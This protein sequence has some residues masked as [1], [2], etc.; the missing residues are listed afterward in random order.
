[1]YKAVLEIVSSGKYVDVTDY[2]RYLIRKDF[3]AR[4]ITLDK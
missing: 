4:G 3:E 2:L 1:M